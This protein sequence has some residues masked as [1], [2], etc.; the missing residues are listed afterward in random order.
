MTLRILRSVIRKISITIRG[1]RRVVHTKSFLIV[2]VLVAT[3]FTFIS[4]GASL[5]WLNSTSNIANN[6]KITVILWHFLIFVAIFTWMRK[7]LLS[8]RNTPNNANSAQIYSAVRLIFSCAF[9][10]LIIIDLLYFID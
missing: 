1:E 7:K 8:L 10:F 6:Y 9:V 3:P 5:D 2:A 4:S